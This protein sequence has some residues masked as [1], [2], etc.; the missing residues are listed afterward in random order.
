MWGSRQPFPLKTLATYN[1]SVPRC[2]KENRSRALLSKEYLRPMYSMG[3]H[4]L[5]APIHLPTKPTH[6]EK[7]AKQKFVKGFILHVMFR[8]CI[9]RKKHRR[10]NA[11]TMCFACFGCRG[12]GGCSWRLWYLGPH[13]RC[14]PHLSCVMVTTMSSNKTNKQD[15]HTKWYK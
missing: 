2:Y 11:C 13:W 3:P 6:A 15:H 12:E 4:A 10:T 9:Q 5:P 14:F 1:S 7:R 8:F